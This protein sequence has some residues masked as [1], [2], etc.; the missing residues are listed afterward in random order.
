M[1]N[2]G[3]W[4]IDVGAYEGSYKI[5][6]GDFYEGDYRIIAEDIFNKEDA[7]FIV[8]ASNVIEEYRTAIRDLDALS[9]E[10]IFE[11]FDM[12]TRSNS[13]I[14]AQISEIISD[15]ERKVGEIA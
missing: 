7:E 3:E 13:D 10:I 14:A 1:V 9:D 5:V 6:T 12:I 15:L 4:R 2:K 8:N 11:E